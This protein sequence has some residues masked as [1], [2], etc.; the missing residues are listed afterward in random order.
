MK[1]IKVLRE[2]A[3]KSEVKTKILKDL[4]AEIKKTLEIVDVEHENF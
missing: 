1:S 4:R 3:G 2:K